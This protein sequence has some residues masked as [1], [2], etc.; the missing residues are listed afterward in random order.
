MERIN[1]R[2]ERRGT[3]A[4]PG[5]KRGKVSAALGLEGEE[6]PELDEDPVGLFLTSRLREPLQ[7][8]HQGLRALSGQS[9]GLTNVRDPSLLD[10]HGWRVDQLQKIGEEVGPRVGP[11]HG[12]DL[13]WSRISSLLQ[14]RSVIECLSKYK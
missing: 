10:R 3:V 14:R 9:R 12:I 13:Y 4:C 6:S 7:C 11:P 5:Q 8:L 2:T 1:Q